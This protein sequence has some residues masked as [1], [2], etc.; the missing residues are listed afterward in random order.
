VAPAKKILI[1]HCSA[2]H[3]LLVSGLVTSVCGK[4]PKEGYTL[5]IPYWRLFKRTR[6]FHITT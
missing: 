5:Q 6:N 3:I 2:K 1:F 4:H